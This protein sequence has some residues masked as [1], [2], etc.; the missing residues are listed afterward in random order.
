MIMYLSLDNLNDIASVSVNS[1]YS[2]NGATENTITNISAEDVV[3]F[4]TGF[5]KIQV[6]AS[7][8]DFANFSVEIT[9]INGNIL[10]YPMVILESE[11]FN[12]N[13]AKN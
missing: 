5:A 1:N 13:L 3:N 4:N 11:T 7:G 10:T 12:K 9:A 2:I 8:F 6:L